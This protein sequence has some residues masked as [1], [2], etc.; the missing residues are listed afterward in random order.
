MSTIKATLKCIKLKL[1][2]M[3]KLGTYE[4]Q[5][6]E[7]N[8]IRRELLAALDY[9]YVPSFNSMYDSTLLEF[10]YTSHQ[11]LTPIAEHDVISLVSNKM[12]YTQ[13]GANH[14]TAFKLYEVCFSLHMFSVLTLD[15]R[16]ECHVIPSC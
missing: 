12:I 6:T 8:I 10:G 7:S 9:E 11:I 14:N 4:E 3:K 1:K 13:L 5:V 16:F 2:D 15:R